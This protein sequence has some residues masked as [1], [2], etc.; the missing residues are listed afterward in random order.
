MAGIGWRLERLI[1]RGVTGAVTAYATGAAVMALPWLLTTAVLLTLPVTVGRGVAGFD[2]ARIVVHVAFAVALLVSGPIQIVI[3]RYSA[4]RIYEGRRWAIAAPFCRGLALTF[5]LCAATAALA[6]L[7]LRVPPAAIPWGAGLAAAVG[8]QW[9][10]LSVGNGLCSPRLVL[11]AVGAGSIVSFLLATVLVGVAGLGAQGYLFGLIAGQ[12][13]T[14]VILLVAI[15]RALPER[16]DEA[17]RLWPAF[18]DYAPLAVS[19]LCFNAS[20]WVDK[21]VAWGS[22]GEKATALHTMASTI[23]WFSTIPCLA[24]VFVA[25]ETRFHRHVRRFYRE[26]ESGASLVELRNGVRALEVEAGRLLSGAVSVQ[27][28]VTIFLQFAAEPW[29][30]RLGLPQEAMLPYRVLLIAAGGQ[31]VGLLGLIVLYYFD[32]RRDAC[33]AGAGLLASVTACSLAASQIGLP[34]SF[35][36]ALGAGVGTALIW[37]RVFRGV[38]DTLPYTLLGQPYMVRPKRHRRWKVARQGRASGQGVCDS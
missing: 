10:A 27:A 25:V 38:R 28:T 1:D 21:W 26:L 13:L 9:T 18:R 17:P 6:L 20:L 35:G 24:W 22:I 29:M 33:L 36:T 34:P 30:S 15:L 5:P 19:G 23:A 14:L 16:S 32:L 3:S 37:S 11:G 7:A 31:A 4:D 8:A 2:T 12:T